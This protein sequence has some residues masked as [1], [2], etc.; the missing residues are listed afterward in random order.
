MPNGSPFN[1]TREQL[2]NLGPVRTVPQLP[3]PDLQRKALEKQ[4]DD[5][6]KLAS[7]A[8]IPQ[9]NTYVDSRTA[10]A[11]KGMLKAQNDDQRRDAQAVAKVWATIAYEVVTAKEQIVTLS[12]QLEEITTRKA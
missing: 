6:R 1:L 11:I 2:V 9:F 7:F 3:D 10:G 4:I 8:E 12:A 5:L